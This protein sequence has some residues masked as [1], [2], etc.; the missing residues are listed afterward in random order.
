[1]TNVALVVLDTLRKDAFDREFDWLPGRRFDR[2]FATAN[3][4][5]P[6]HASLFTGRYASEVGVQARSRHLDWEG[7]VL[8]ERFRDAGYTTRGISA[9]VNV[10]PAFGFDRGFEAFRDLT[11]PGD[12]ETFDWREFRA[13]RPETGVELYLRAVG[14]CLRSDTPT[15]RSLL[16]GAR[17]KLDSG[18]NVAFGGAEETLEA[19]REAEFGDREFL[20]LNLMEAHEPYRVP[21][22]Y[23]SVPEPELTRAV[24][25]CTLTEV[26][27]ERT[28]R[29]Y[30][31]CARYLSDRYRELFAVFDDAFDYVITC[32]DHGELLG[33]HGG[34][35]H[36]YGVYPELTHV[37]LCISG[38]GL[39]GVEDAPASLLDVHAT[40]L[41]LAGLDADG[42]G[43]HL[44]DEPSEREYLSEY[45]GLTFDAENKLREYGYADEIP[46]YAEEQYG[47]VAGS[48]DYGY[49]VPGGYVP[50]CSDAAGEERKRLR[51]LVATLD[52]REVVEDDEAVPSSVRDRLEDLGYA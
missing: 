39:D 31:D 20:Y 45:L 37:P 49:E 27:A 19:V 1:M 15:L 24:G 22:D 10:S 12:G 41:G 42:R 13:D 3:W 33:E 44:L 25:D 43:Q 47:R 16:A 26:D 40:L 8:A 28:R 46:T 50:G 5:V 7:E 21:E 2:A 17:M 36:E 9:N 38:P 51:R 35:A 14:A 18:E 6:S 29:A 52:H 48:G 23:R 34:W 30:D 11:A 32:A 4:T